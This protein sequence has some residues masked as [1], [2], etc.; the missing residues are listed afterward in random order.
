VAN[1]GLAPPPGRDLIS[2]LRTFDIHDLIAQQ[3]FLG[4]RK[5]AVQIM[6]R[7]TEELG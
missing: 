3:K 6:S 2:A 1:E 5:H 7:G 4:F